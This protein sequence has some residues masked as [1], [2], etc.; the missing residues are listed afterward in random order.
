MA[1]LREIKDKLDLLLG[2][3]DDTVRFRQVLLESLGAVE[4]KQEALGKQLEGISKIQD[5]EACKL[6]E[7]TGYC[8]VTA[9]I[10]TKL[11]TL[12]TKLDAG[13]KGT[14]DGVGSELAEMRKTIDALI[15]LLCP[16]PAARGGTIHEIK[17]G[18]WHATY[19]VPTKQ[20]NCAS[21]KP[22]TVR[23]G[24]KKVR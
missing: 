17:Q 11:K 12:E 15:N 21:S 5:I 3:K 10:V 20:K 18:T 7:L 2:I 19:D 24:R 6:T 13:L 14:A 16:I 4:R 23:A 9:E 8:Q 1:S 22:P